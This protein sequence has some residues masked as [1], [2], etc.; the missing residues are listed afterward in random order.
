MKRTFLLWPMLLLAG[1]VFGQAKDGIVVYKKTHQP[2]ATI[3]LP[4][5]PEVVTAA[6]DGYLSKKGLKSK[7]LKG[8]K[9][10]RNT[11]F[12]QGD[13]MNADLYFKVTRNNRSQIEASIIY[14][15]VG[16][17]NE[18][19]EKR[20]QETH[21]TRQQAK[22]YLNNLVPVIEAYNLELLII[23]QNETVIEEEKR[24]NS[25][26]DDGADLNKRKTD[27][28][29]KLQRN[30]HDQDKQ[31]EEVEKHKQALAYLISQRKS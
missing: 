22:E 29:Q 11:Q 3:S 12:V 6:M 26:V 17:P 25:L 27:N 13:S 30:Q 2:A 8:F 28:V 10:F 19:I 5:E 21:F 16:M 1:C 31:N 14:L 15:M 20:N 4:Y 23:Q 18:N 9:T 24:Y 7:D